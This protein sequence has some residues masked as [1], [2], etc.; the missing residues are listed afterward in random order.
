MQSLK[1]FHYYQDCI[2]KDRE[3]DYDKVEETYQKNLVIEKQNEEIIKENKVLYEDVKNAILKAGMPLSTEVK[4]G[5]ALESF[6]R[7]HFSKYLKMNDF[8]AQYQ[9]I[10]GDR[11]KREQEKLNADKRKAEDLAKEQKA[12]EKERVLGYF[13]MKYGLDMNSDAG[14]ILDHL[15]GKN[16]YLRLAH[17]LQMN[18][19]DWSDGYNYAETG[20][21]GFKIENDMDN[22]IYDEIEGIIG[23][24][25]VDG[26]YFRDCQYNYDYI[27]SLVQKENPE[28][29]KD[30]VVISEIVDGERW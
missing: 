20:L 18:R 21:N 10:M 8:K 11:Q 7:D 19:S 3:W 28:L 1:S 25:D 23:N 22:E 12:K 26:R 4:R 17:Y 14:D 6:F 15:L 13:V 2:N 16:K 30:Y 5:L 29:L 24:D 27:F 9:K